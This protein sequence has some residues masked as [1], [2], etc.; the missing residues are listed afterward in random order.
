MDQ[1]AAE[2]LRP[3][4][5]GF[6]AGLVSV[7]GGTWLFSGDPSGGVASLGLIGG[8]AVFIWTLISAVFLIRSATD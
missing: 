7:I 4:I 3:C 8:L 1:E 6:V 2:D 5:L